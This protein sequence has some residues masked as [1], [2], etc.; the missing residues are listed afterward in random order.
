[1]QTVVRRAA[2]LGN[3]PGVMPKPCWQLNIWYTPIDG[4]MAQVGVKE[5]HELSGI[6]CERG[7]GKEGCAGAILSM[8]RINVVL[9]IIHE[10]AD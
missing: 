10:K 2:H 6:N 9:A 7:P 5:S 3:H 1:M 4:K 8:G